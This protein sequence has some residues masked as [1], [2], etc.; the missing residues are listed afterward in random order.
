MK[1]LLSN[2]CIRLCTVNVQ[3]TKGFKIICVIRNLT[4]TGLLNFCIRIC[5]FLCLS[6]KALSYFR[7]CVSNKYNRTSKPIIT[8]YISQNSVWI[9]NSKRSITFIL[10]FKIITKSIRQNKKKIVLKMT[11][12][13]TNEKLKKIGRQPNFAHI[14]C[15]QHFVFKHASH[16]SWT[17]RNC[18]ENNDNFGWSHLVYYYSNNKSLPTLTCYLFFF[19]VKLKKEIILWK[20]FIKK[21]S[22]HK[23]LYHTIN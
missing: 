9:N 1:Y 7:Y 15:I 2:M 23:I 16:R 18:S 20:S 22:I 3:I 17:G 4:L 13:K 5:V 11:T 6:R 8:A 12:N 19:Y 21:F 10:L 14:Y